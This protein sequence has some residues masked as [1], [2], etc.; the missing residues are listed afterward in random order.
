MHGKIQTHGERMKIQS[1][2]IL[3]EISSSLLIDMA[4]LVWISHIR[5]LESISLSEYK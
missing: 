4:F 5:P 3:S 1:Q 2:I